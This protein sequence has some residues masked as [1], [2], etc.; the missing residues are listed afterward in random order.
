MNLAPHLAELEF[1]PHDQPTTTQL[2]A[3]WKELCHKHHPDKGGS[4]EKFQRVTHAYK[5]ITDPEYRHREEIAEMKRSNPNAKGDLNLRIVL[6]VSFEDAFFGRTMSISYSILHY[7]DDHEIIP[8]IG[9]ADN[10]LVCHQLTLRLQPG[11][12]ATYET[13]APGK[14]HRC[15]DRVGNALIA[16]SPL[17]HMKFRVEGVDVVSSE[18]LPLDVMLKGGKIDAPTLYGIKRATVKPGTRPGDSLVIR[19]CGVNQQGNHRVVVE[20]IYPTAEDLKG[21]AWAGLKV[22]W[23]TAAEADAEAEALEK[24]FMQM[25]GSQTFTIRFG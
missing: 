19:R 1:G 13:M 8:L 4:G 6:P 23:A 5:M 9:K 11:V 24:V 22:D 14:G 10:Q 2:K 25:G 21:E 15:G 3:R 12:M 16:V 7:N 18:K 17:P 20:P